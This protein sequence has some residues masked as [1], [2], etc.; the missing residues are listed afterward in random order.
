ML[1]MAPTYLFLMAGYWLAWVMAEAALHRKVLHGAE[2]PKRPFRLG[3]D[4][5]RVWLAQL[6]VFGLIFAIYFFGVMA[7]VLMAAIPGIGPILAVFGLICLLY[8]SP[9]PRDQRGSR[10]PSSA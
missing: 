7:F 5:L 9:S 3:K 1:K 4:E 6:G 8:T 2:A 10:M